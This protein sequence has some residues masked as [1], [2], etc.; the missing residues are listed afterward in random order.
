MDVVNSLASDPLKLSEVF[1]GPASNVRIKELKTWLVAKGVLDFEPVPLNYQNIRKVESLYFVLVQ[2]FDVRAQ[3]TVKRIEELIDELSARRGQMRKVMVN[4]I[5][6]QAILKPAHAVYRLQ[7]QRFDI[8]D[9]VVMV[10]DSEPVPLSAK[11]V[12]VG[13]KA[14][15]LDVVW[16][17]FFRSGSTLGNRCVTHPNCST[18]DIVD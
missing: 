17:V 16:D 4:G 10:K 1:P 15:M 6:R 12:V 7:S 11:G 9:R 13:I 2:V 8:G 18:R 14:K 5:P 3:E